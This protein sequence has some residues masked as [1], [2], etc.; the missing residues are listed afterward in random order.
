MLKTV[1][2]LN[3]FVETM[4]LFQESLRNRKLKKQHLFETAMFFNHVNVYSHFLSLANTNI[5][6]III[7]QI[8]RNL[9]DI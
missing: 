3:V 7:F 5:L 6:L 9:T 2:L 1:V 8:K 4:I